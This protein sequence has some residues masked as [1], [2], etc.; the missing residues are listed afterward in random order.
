MCH[1][2][3]ARRSSIASS[4]TIWRPFSPHSTLIPTPEVCPPMW[5]ANCTTICSAASSHMVSSGWAVTPATRS[6]CWPSAAS[7]GGFVRRVPGGA[8]PHPAMG[9]VGA[10]LPRL[11]RRRGASLTAPLPLAVLDGRVPGADGAGPYHH[12]H[13]NRAVL[14]EQGRHPRPEAS[15]HATGVGDV[16]PAFR[17]CHEFEPPFPLRLP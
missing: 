2:I 1:A 14:Y 11:R 5:N 13:H 10:C 9:R 7:G 12:P 3:R 4:P 8:C 16:Y 17:E 6:C 15:Q